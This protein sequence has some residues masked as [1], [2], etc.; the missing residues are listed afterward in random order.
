MVRIVERRGE[1]C[2][3]L[4]LYAAS[5]KLS[6][7]FPNINLSFS[8]SKSINWDTSPWARRP[9]VL[10]IA[11]IGGIGNQLNFEPITPGFSGQGCRILRP[12]IRP[13]AVPLNPLSAPAAH[14]VSAGNQAV[15]VLIRG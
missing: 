5:T 2:I 14:R 1:V 3:I 7:I 12:P 13:P 11:K 9:G 10:F 6:M 8:S 4:L 15:S